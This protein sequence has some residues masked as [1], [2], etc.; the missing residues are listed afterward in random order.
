[1]N[2]YVNK[3]FKPDIL[4]FLLVHNDFHES[5]ARYVKKPYFLQ[6]DFMDDGVYEIDPTKRRLYQFLTYSALFRYLYSNLNLASL[7]FD[8]IEK[9]KNYNANIDAEGVLKQKDRITE[10]TKYLIGKIKLEN[11]DKRVILMMDAPRNDIYEDR[12][13]S[14]DVL[15]LNKMVARIARRYEVELLDLTDVFY[16]D[17]KRNNLRFNSE[18]DGHWNEY[19]HYMASEALYNY[20]VDQSGYA[21]YSA[22]AR[23]RSHQRQRRQ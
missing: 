7:Y 13:T 5:I 16:N 3:Q 21:H 15:W 2:R 9:P 1:M 10:V 22:D 20:L 4:I 14:S 12:V 11:R 23:E 18:L 19:G 17:Y 8:I 6:M